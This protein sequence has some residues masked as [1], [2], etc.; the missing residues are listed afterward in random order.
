M[1]SIYPITKIR[2]GNSA[3]LRELRAIAKTNAKAIIAGVDQAKILMS[4][5]NA[6]SNL[7]NESINLSPL[8]NDSLTRSQ[9]GRR[10]T[11]NISSE[12]TTTVLSA[13][14]MLRYSLNQEAAAQ[15]IESAVKTVL[16]Q[17]LRTADIFSAGMTRVG[18]LEMGA[19]VVR[20]LK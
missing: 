9:R 3:G 7:G 14:M 16:N 2:I 4:K 20:A 19:A 11:R 12:T 15:R 1:T 10:G 8:K 5:T 13:A 18:T 6:L 17:G